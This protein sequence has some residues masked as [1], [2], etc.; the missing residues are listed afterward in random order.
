M[1]VIIVGKSVNHPGN[2]TRTQ[3]EVQY[4]FDIVQFLI[5]LASFASVIYGGIINNRVVKT[6]T[7]N[8]KTRIK[9]EDLEKDSEI[10]SYLSRMLEVSNGN[11]ALV[12]LF[13]NGTDAGL[14]PFKYF[15]VFWEVTSGDGIRKFKF[16]NQH[17]PFDR[18]KAEFKKCAENPEDFII[19]SVDDKDIL[20]GCKAY[21]LAND[22]HT[23]VSRLI[24]NETKG[25]SGIFNLHYNH[26][27]GE[28][29]QKT[30]DRLTELFIVLESK[31]ERE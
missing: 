4:S 31:I 8:A 19:Q 13:T 10:E 23:I 2:P 18:I 9:P 7:K 17:R 5:L 30:L 6:T 29:S 11:R 15:S 14:F 20:E 26:D 12:A 22:I 3:T 21:L 25:F 16:D 1:A 28:I 27:P 24:G